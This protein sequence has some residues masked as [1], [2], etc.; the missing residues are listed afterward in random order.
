MTG[1]P[2]SYHDWHGNLRRGSPW[3]PRDHERPV[4]ACPDRLMTWRI[5][6]LLMT[7]AVYC[8]NN[9]NIDTLDTRHYH[10]NSRTPNHILGLS[11][12]ISILYLPLLST[13]WIWVAWSVP[14]WLPCGCFVRKIGSACRTWRQ[15]RGRWWPCQLLPWPQKWANAATASKRFEVKYYENYCEILLTPLL[16]AEHSTIYYL[17]INYSDWCHCMSPVI[18]V[19]ANQP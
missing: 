4:L 18:A 12:A 15:L 16:P 3:P 13:S 2:S 10:W 17:F 8:I 6:L 1:V 14:S 9:M 5:I 11:T 7:V 19:S